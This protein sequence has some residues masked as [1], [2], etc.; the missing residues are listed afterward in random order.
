MWSVAELP[1]AA[2]LA[3]I[4]IIAP[5]AAGPTTLTA[6]FADGTVQ[7]RTRAHVR[8]SRGR[9]RCLAQHVALQRRG[10]RAWGLTAPPPLH[11]SGV[12]GPPPLH[13]RQDPC[14]QACRLERAAP[15]PISN[16]ADC[17]C[18]SGALLL[19]SFKTWAGRGAIHALSPCVIGRWRSSLAEFREGG[20]ELLDL[21]VDVP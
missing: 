21:C 15:G 16:Q 8:R 6:I 5:G 17:D 19:G 1:G 4:D 12:S 18:V 10:S 7:A 11:L 9:G 2:E 20:A 13:Q 3:A 14:V